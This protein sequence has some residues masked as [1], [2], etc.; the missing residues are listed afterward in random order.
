MGVDWV[1][2]VMVVTGGDLVDEG[3]DVEDFGCWDLLLR[4][5]KLEISACSDSGDLS[6]LWKNIACK[7][8]SSQFDNL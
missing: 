2:C 3:G 1:D 5:G 8:T 7:H 6:V 4:N